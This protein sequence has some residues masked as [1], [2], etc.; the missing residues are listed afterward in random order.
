M[1]RQNSDVYTGSYN[2]NEEGN[3]LTDLPNHEEKTHQKL[4]GIKRRQETIVVCDN[5]VH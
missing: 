1:K 4:R 3:C 5:F 2:N